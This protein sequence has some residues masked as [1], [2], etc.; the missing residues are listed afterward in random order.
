L[1]LNNF[2]GDHD[3]FGSVLYSDCELM[4]NIKFSLYKSAD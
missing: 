3:I 2:V 4:V 1:K